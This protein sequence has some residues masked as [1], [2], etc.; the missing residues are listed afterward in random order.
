MPHSFENSGA[1]PSP[2]DSRDFH[3]YHVRGELGAFALPT[4]KTINIPDVSFIPA[5]Y[6]GKTS[7]CVPHSRTW[8][9][10]YKYW[11]ANKILLTLSP[12]FGY[13]IDKAADGIPQIQ[14]TSPRIDLKQFQGKGEC[15][16][17]L[18]PND[19]TLPLPQYQDAKLIPSTA[20]VA[21]LK[22]NNINYI[23]VALDPDSIK[24]AIDDWSVVLACVSIGS[25]WWTSPT[26]VTSWSS[27]DVL[28]V[29]PPATIISGHQIA[30]YGYDDTYFYF[31]NSFG[32][33]WGNNGYGYMSISSYMKFI[34]ECWSIEALPQ[35]VVQGIKVVIQQTQSIPSPVSLSWLDR[36]ILWLMG[37]PTPS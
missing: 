20:T 15:D 28:P 8:A 13:A 4:H 35:E 26:G 33:A 27:N 30:I 18:F 37:G 21:A 19:V 14:G 23:S 11:I 24:A 34:K 1:Y 5:L 12:R 25:E 31:A 17:S 7:A 16:V 9:F 29:R 3:D 32:S 22:Y 10:H 36:L 2:A 6:Q